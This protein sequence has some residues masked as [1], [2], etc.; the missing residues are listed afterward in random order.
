ME[1]C[2]CIYYQPMAL[3]YGMDVAEVSLVAGYLSCLSEISC[4]KSGALAKPRCLC[5]EIDRA[6]SSAVANFRRCGV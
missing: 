6:F 3:I 4:R 5:E 2:R 1:I